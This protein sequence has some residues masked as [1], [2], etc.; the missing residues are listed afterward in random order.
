MATIVSIIVESTLYARRRGVSL[1]CILKTVE[2]ARL[3]RRGTTP[4]ESPGTITIELQ[5]ELSQETSELGGAPLRRGRGEPC[6]R[7][8]RPEAQSVEAVLS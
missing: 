4:G 8:R 5:R 6:L 2:Y 1:R 3:Q 7:R